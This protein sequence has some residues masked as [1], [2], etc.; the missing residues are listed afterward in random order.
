MTEYKMAYPQERWV[1]EKFILAKYADAVANGEAE[2]IGLTDI[3][4][5][6]EELEDIGQVTFTT[7][8]RLSTSMGNHTPVKQLTAFE[9]KL[10]FKSVTKKDTYKNKHHSH[11]QKH[12]A[13]VF[14]EIERRLS[15]KGED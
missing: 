5:I 13:E 2:L 4:E 10:E 8:E 11:F 14:A 15:N 3:R 9:L 1:N 7:E 12:K 6:M